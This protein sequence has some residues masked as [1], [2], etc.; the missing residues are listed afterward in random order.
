MTHRADHDVA[1]PDD[2]AP[3]S[4]ARGGAPGKSTLTSR[5]WRSARR[6]DRGVAP[7]AEEAVA[8][9]GG[10]GAPLPA[11]VRDRFEASLGADLGAVRVHTDDASATAADAVGARAFARGNDI[12]FGAGQY[13]PDDPFG[14][15]L[16]A[17]EVAHTVQQSGGAAT[18]QYK[19][20]VSYPG[21]AAE[22][23]ADRAADAMVSGQVASV[24]G[25][26]AVVQRSADTHTAHLQGAGDAAYAGQ[27]KAQ[28]AFDQTSVSVDIGRA[29]A[30]LKDIDAN[31][32]VIKAAVKQS[33]TLE[34]EYGMLS[35]TTAT[36]A[37]LSVFHDKLDVSNVDTAAFA[38][39]YRVANADFARLSAEATEYLTRLGVDTKGALDTVADGFGKTPGLKL[40]D[41]QTGLDRFRAA[42]NNLHTANKKM[43]AQMSKCRGAANLLQGAIYKA[44]A[45]A[46][47]AKGKDAANKLA[48]LRREIDAMAANVGTVVK[49]ASGVAGLAGGGGAT[50]GLAVPKEDPAG[51]D[52]QSGLDKGIFTVPGESVVINPNDT[53]KDGKLIENKEKSLGAYAPVAKALGSD[54]SSLIG[55]G[56]GPA[57]LA[58]GLVKFIGDQVNKDKIAALQQAI[59][60]K[61]AEEESFSIAGDA[62]NFTGY[63]EQMEGASQDLV[64]LV[65]AFHAAKGE[66][67]EASDALIKAL[68]ASGKKGQDQAKGVMFL[69]DADTF[70]AQVGNAIATGE[71]QQKN[72]K[73]AALD[74][75]NLR[76]TSGI[77]GEPDRKAQVY[78]RC[79][80]STTTGTFWDSTAFK[81]ERVFV[82]FTT[83][84][85]M[86]WNALVQGG[87]GTVEGDGSAED[88]VAHKIEQLKTKRTQVTNLQAKVQK[89]LGLG[90][91][92]LQA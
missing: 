17:H 8:G 89:A 81:P 43:G 45:A 11:G 56:G 66:M 78:W 46:A 28:V 10:G 67:T 20:A 90:G 39:Q 50:A 35:S 73:S 58:E 41:A 87:T 4:S 55:S 62:S 68:N 88:V 65:E 79:Q 82:T 38:T 61:A 64:N 33:P 60:A 19:L 51:V 2:Y 40:G 59:I 22:V 49:L 37:K 52:I 91:P 54:L 84:A 5:L 74:R 13:Q 15:H 16:L 23:E 69:G 25:A 80:K 27:M 24:R 12:H 86:D 63:Q 31:L 47:A 29:D 53:Y 1:G 26:T 14:M 75:K 70:L 83:G 6:D 48:D 77:E 85:G 7:G 44:K 9:L 36:R 76:G 57:G 34:N 21:D 18:T 3:P 30:M 71:N 32:P 42:R 92:V 72:L